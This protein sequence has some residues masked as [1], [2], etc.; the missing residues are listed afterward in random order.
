MQVNLKLFHA[1]TGDTIK[2]STIK[3]ADKSTRTSLVILAKK[4]A[5]LSGVPSTTKS[6]DINTHIVHVPSALHY[7][8]IVVDRLDTTYADQL[9]MKE[10]SKYVWYV[11]E[12]S[13][14]MKVMKGVWR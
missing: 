7:I 6:T 11:S 10:N 9:I 12:H 4:W 2:S 13:Y 3:V 8:E 14:G 1:T 5:H